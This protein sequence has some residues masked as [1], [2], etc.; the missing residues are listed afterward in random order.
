MQVQVRPLLESRLLALHDWFEV[1]RPIC[2]QC[3]EELYWSQRRFWEGKKD[4]RV[5]FFC[6]C[7]FENPLTYLQFKWETEQELI[8]RNIEIK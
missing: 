8:A 6:D 3:K 4:K 1:V 2:F 7:G 5:Y